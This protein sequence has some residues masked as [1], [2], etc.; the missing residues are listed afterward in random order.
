MH[1][2]AVSV[3]CLLTVCGMANAETPT[4]PENCPSVPSP[5]TVTKKQGPDFDVCY[6]RAQG[7]DGFFGIYLGFHPMFRPS[8]GAKGV[9]GSVGGKPVEWFVKTPSPGAPNFAQEALV[10]QSRGRCN[11]ER[12]Q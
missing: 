1:S 7:L 10:F 8:S 9:A 12:L 2:S 3:A 6:Y 5:W 4:L 11:C